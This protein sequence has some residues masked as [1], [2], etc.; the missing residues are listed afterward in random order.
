MGGKPTSR[1]Q[2]EIEREKERELQQQQKM[3]RQQQQH[4]QMRTR[5][6][7]LASAVEEAASVASWS[8]LLKQQVW[9]PWAGSWFEVVVP[10][11]VPSSARADV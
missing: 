11:Q 1:R 3:R 9:V 4:S 5:K 10:R 2:G 7:L 6:K 8:E